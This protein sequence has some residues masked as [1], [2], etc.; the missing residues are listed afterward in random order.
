[1]HFLADSG[2]GACRTR[3]FLLFLGLAGKA[4]DFQKIAALL[5]FFLVAAL[6][7]V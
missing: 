3:V 1:V 4:T 2:C 5:K 6:A 7:K